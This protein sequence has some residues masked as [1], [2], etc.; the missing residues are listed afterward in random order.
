[1]SA[2]RAGSK[3]LIREI[4]QSIVL[5]AIRSRGA[6]S[7]TDIAASANLS[8]ATISGITAELIEA[9][10]IYEKTNGV[11]TGGRRPVLLALNARAGYAVGI[12]LTE[13][14]AIAV[15][16][17][18]DATIV[19]RHSE[20]ILS[21][22]PEAIIETL[23][24]AV[25]VLA[26]AAHG[27]PI[28]GVGIGMAGIID[29]AHALVHY[30]TY[31]GWRALPLAELLEAQISLPVVID[32]DVNALTV[33]EQWFG[34]GK[35]VED[36]LVISLGRGVGLGMVLDG[37]LYRGARGGAGEFGHTTIVPDGPRCVCGK[38]GCLEALVGDP[39][40]MQRA[41]QA[42][43][44]PATI[45]EAIDLA[46]HGDAALLSLFTA[47]G[48]TLGLAVANLVNVL[49]PSLIIIGG[50]GTRAGA[51][52]IEPFQAALRANCFDGLCD[53]LRVVTEPWGDE[54]WARGAASLLLSE[55]FQPALRRGEE[56][57]PSLTA[58]NS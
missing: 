51:L 5:N 30:A 31:F 7:R 23:A 55:L 19:A 16:T 34:A 25:R 41:A 54:A 4:N 21:H 43:G 11:S 18:L 2:L 17:D 28:F 53:D 32:N 8:L 20:P 22:Q 36:F 39:A 45:A 15:L 49:N 47:A 40:L 48:R 56:E 12:K 37:R 46:S 33:A 1:M 10:L 13:T 50:E 6:L 26:S 35:G 3:Q 57:R 44:R 42:L 29:R 24:A 52:V 9:G 38:Y 58:R 27:R 14:T